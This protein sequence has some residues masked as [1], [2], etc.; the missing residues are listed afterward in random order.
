LVLALEKRGQAEGGARFQVEAV[1]AADEARRAHLTK[2]QEAQERRNA[3]S[4]EIGNAM[5]S[6]DSALAERL[7]AEVAELKSF[8]QDGEAEERRLDEALRDQ[9]ARIPNLPLDDVPVGTDENDN[10]QIR[11]VGEPGRP[12]GA[13]EHF[14]IGERLGMMDF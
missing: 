11:R 6:G 2:L 13:R 12:N 1:I 14:E 5:R 8:V 7:K 4:R 3:A 10:V 9:L